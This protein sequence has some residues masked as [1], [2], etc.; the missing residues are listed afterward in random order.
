MGTPDYEQLAKMLGG[1]GQQQ[2]QR[3]P[4]STATHIREQIENKRIGCGCLGLLIA[5][6]FGVYFAVSAWA[7]SG[8]LALVSAAVLAALGVASVYMKGHHVWTG[9]SW[10]G[11][12]VVGVG[13]T[14]MIYTQLYPQRAAQLLPA[15]A[16]DPGTPTILALAGLGSVALAV[17]RMRSTIT[18]PESLYAIQFHAAAQQVDAEALTNQLK[19][20]EVHLRRCGQMGLWP[21][22][23][24][25]I[26][27]GDVQEPPK[28]HQ[29][30][31]WLPLLAIQVVPNDDPWTGEFGEQ[32]WLEIPDSPRSTQETIG[33]LGVGILLFDEDHLRFVPLRTHLEPVTAPLARLTRYRM[34]INALE[35]EVAQE[36]GDPKVYAFEVTHGWRVLAMAAFLRVYRAR[37]EEEAVLWATGVRDGMSGEATQAFET[38]PTGAEI[39]EAVEALR[40][41][42]PAC[43]EA[44]EDAMGLLVELGGREEAPSRQVAA[45]LTNLWQ[46]VVEGGDIDALEPQIEDLSNL[47]GLFPTEV[48]PD[49][50]H[51]LL[52]DL[53]GL[54]MLQGK[55]WE[56]LKA[57]VEEWS[58]RDL[59]W[60]YGEDA[61][62]LPEGV[63]EEE[64]LEE[65]KQALIDLVQLTRRRRAT[66]ERARE[67]A[68]EA[69]KAFPGSL[70]VDAL[71]PK[72]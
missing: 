2:P 29:G 1:G 54:A 41:R 17:Y 21:I 34:R 47:L 69:S 59:E 37:M 27:M 15:W 72:A 22:G 20:L 30:R 36:Q 8:D 9:V 40:G 51:E 57:L 58:A 19:Q 42:L 60:L 68:E 28:G 67:L 61:E 23:V 5:C 55:A 4:R 49:E 56:P 12:A 7:G 63:S 25:Y 16:L 14:P 13:A 44:M 53:V 50:A 70:L 66:S 31:C 52:E 33:P 18:T 62:A 65:S 11:L 48:W 10:L 24:E 38:T 45:R 6:L 71:T 26:N 32:P 64:A 3:D 46:D 35:I 43:T 39:Q